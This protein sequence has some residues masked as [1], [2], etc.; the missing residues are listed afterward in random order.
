MTE[1]D[2]SPAARTNEYATFFIVSPYLSPA[3]DDDVPEGRLQHHFCQS[4]LAPDMS[5]VFI[6]EA[7]QPSLKRQQLP[8]F[9]AFS[10]GFRIKLMSVARTLHFWGSKLP[11][12]RYF[13]CGEGWNPHRHRPS[14]PYYG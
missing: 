7:A 3:P 10:A 14:L 1:E 5:G 8:P 11:R 12:C 6:A 13:R 4:K 2:A 9:Y